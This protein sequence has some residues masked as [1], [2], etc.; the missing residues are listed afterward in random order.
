MKHLFTNKSCKYKRRILFWMT[1]GS[2]IFTEFKVKFTVTYSL[3]TPWSRILPEKLT[4]PQ[5]VRKFPAFYETRNLITAFIRASH[6]PCFSFYRST[7][8]VPKIW[9]L[10]LNMVKLLLWGVLAP[11]PPPKL[12]DYPLSA[13]RDCL[14]SIFASTLH[15]LR[16]FLHPQPEDKSCHGDRDR[17]TAVSRTHLLLWQGPTYYCDRDLLITVTGTHLP[18]WQGPTY[19]C[20]RD[21]LFTVTG[22]QLL[23]W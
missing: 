3:L 11:R 9:L 21:L 7:S 6:L 22:T 4:G 16:P 13:V 15:I 10:F 8:P 2:K 1:Y 20:D 14:F 5:I 19:Y 18:L 12:E 23:L 17:L